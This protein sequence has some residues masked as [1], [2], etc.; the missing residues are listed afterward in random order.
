MGVAG[1]VGAA[2]GVA[3]VG[4]GILRNRIRCCCWRTGGRHY[5]YCC[6]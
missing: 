3:G 5:C 1:A 4:I 6:C 2:G